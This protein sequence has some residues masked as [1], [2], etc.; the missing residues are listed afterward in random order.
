MRA[1]EAEEKRKEAEEQR[2]QQELLVDVTSHGSYFDSRSVFY[3]QI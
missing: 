2:R 3:S 1:E